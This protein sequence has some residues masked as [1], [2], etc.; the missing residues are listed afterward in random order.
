MV[1]TVVVA[2]TLVV[3]V[4]WILGQSLRLRVRVDL[5]TLVVEIPLRVVRHK[6]V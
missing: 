5:D 4:W 6:I 1:L 2:V 3:V